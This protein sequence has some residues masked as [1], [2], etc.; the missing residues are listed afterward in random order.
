M[1]VHQGRIAEGSDADIVVWDGNATRT[2]SK[3]TH[4]QAVDFNIFEGMECH[5]VPVYVLTKGNVV[6]DNGEVTQ[7][8]TICHCMSIILNDAL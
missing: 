6:V 4:H 7:K 5:G 1:L 8:I 2:I 3:D